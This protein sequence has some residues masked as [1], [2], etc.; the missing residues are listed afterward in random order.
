M[1]LSFM[2]EGAVSDSEKL[3]R[4]IDALTPTGS[5]AYFHVDGYPRKA[6]QEDAVVA[7]QALDTIT[8]ELEDQKTMVRELTSRVNLAYGWLWVAAAE[9]SIPR[10]CPTEKALYH[11]RMTL[12]EGMS[13][14]VR[15]KAISEILS[16]VRSPE[17]KA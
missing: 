5:G 4:F 3:H 7:L 16:I 17:A 1:G 6:L 13:E 2:D 10:Y 11:A 14:D 8:K 12:R 15:G 9:P